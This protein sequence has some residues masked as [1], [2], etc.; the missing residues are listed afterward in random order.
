MK[1]KYLSVFASLLVSFAPVPA[2]A[3]NTSY[4]ERPSMDDSAPVSTSTGRDK[5]IYDQE[6]GEGDLYCRRKLGSWFYCDKPKAKPASPASAPPPQISADAQLKEIGKQLDELKAQAILEPTEANVLAYIRFQREQLDRSSTFADVWQRALWQNPQDD[7]TLQRPVST[8]GK[9][10]WI[11]NRKA[12]RNAAMARLS[13]RYGVYYFY[14]QS[15]SA[16]EIQAPILK[17]VSDSNHL[18][19]VAVSMDGGPNRVFPNYVVDSGQRARMGL[20]GNA[21]PALVL[22]DTL[23]KR[24]IPIGTGLMAADEIMDR[25][26][27]L[28]KT[29]PG[30]DF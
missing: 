14:A 19:V 7:Y 15:C 29:K 5:G 3:Q 26:F 25:I 1:I 8:I 23:T 20:P 10:A 30:S 9:R 13:Q 4:Q 6:G 12:D 17:S 24:P 22:F 28:T 2:I 11:D 27:V 18:S 16:C 21:T